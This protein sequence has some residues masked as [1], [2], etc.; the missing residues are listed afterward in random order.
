MSYKWQCR[1]VW[2]EEEF[3]HYYNEIIEKAKNH[4]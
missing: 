3:D 1:V 4:G 2:I